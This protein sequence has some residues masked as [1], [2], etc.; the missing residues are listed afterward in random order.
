MNLPMTRQSLFCGVAALLFMTGCYQ[1]EKTSPDDRGTDVHTGLEYVNLPQ[2]PFV[3]QGQEPGWRLRITGQAIELVEDYGTSRSSFPHVEPTI[4]AGS[5]VRYRTTNDDHE[6]EIFVEPSI[7]RDSMSGMPHPA[8]VRYALDGEMSN[9]CG[10]A[11]EDLLLG[12]EWRVS[13]IAGEAVLEDAAPTIEFVAEDS[14]VA[15][16]AGCNRF[17]GT[18]ELTGEGLSFSPLGTTM[19]A[20]AAPGVQEQERRFLEVMQNT[21]RF[22]M[23]DFDRLRLITSDNEIIEASR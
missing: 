10:G 2:T 9:G 8:T 19:M 3:A 16:E 17:I 21:V 18:F 6:L 5:I 7:C 23:P 22:E 4:T 15:G 20:C 1:P 13:S 12:D 11:P 14:R